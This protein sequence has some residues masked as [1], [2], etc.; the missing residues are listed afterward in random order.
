MSVL[1]IIQRFTNAVGIDEPNTALANTNDD[2]VQIVEL[3]NQEGRD[4]S[5]RH[6]WQQLTYEVTF[7]TLAAESQGTIA[8]IIGATQEM[9][10]IVNDTIWNRTQQRQIFG[11]LSKR[12]WQARKATTLTGPWQQY[13]IRGDRIIFNPAPPAG[14]TC[15]LEYVSK[16]WLTDVSGATYRRNAVAD[17]DVVLLEDDLILLGLEW[18]WLRRKGLSYAEEFAT[19]EGAVKTAM[20]TNG[21]KRRLNAADD[22]DGYRPGVFVPIGS[23]SV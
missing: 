13:R 22:M 20:S 23:W 8:S 1:E 2:V 5:R 9:R 14:E 6:D 11:P 12:E 10:K 16:C 3:L 7:T 15:A 19:Y 4:L 21:T 18:R 17:T